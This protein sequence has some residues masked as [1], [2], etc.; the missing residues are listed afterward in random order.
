M[1]TDMYGREQI[2]AYAA[3][4]SAFYIHLS[5]RGRRVRRVQNVL[6]VWEVCHGYI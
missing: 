6:F 2:V 5:L 3:V 1:L 4:N